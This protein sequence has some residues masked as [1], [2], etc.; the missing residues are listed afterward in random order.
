MTYCVIISGK[1]IPIL[2]STRKRDTG[3][4]CMLVVLSA[5]AYFNHASCISFAGEKYA[6]MQDTTSLEILSI[7]L[8]SIL[9]YGQK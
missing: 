2:L 1:F 7:I 5:E 8:P 6:D 3:N 9:M 4:V